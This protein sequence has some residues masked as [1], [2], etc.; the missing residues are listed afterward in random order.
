[1]AAAHKGE[2]IAIVLDGVIKSAPTIQ[3][4][5]FDGKPTITGQFS[6]GEAKDLALVLRYGALPVQLKEQSV[7]KV[8]ATLGTDSLKAG[9]IAGLVG[10]GLVL[11]YMLFYY[12]ALGAVV[13]M[14]L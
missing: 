1:M 8:S 6:Q 3:A 4:V 12:R 13:L 7:E 10:L 11:L 9:V 5:S 14:G 2:Q